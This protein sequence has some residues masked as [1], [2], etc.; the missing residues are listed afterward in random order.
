MTK[1]VAIITA[2]GRGKRMG[3][4][5]Q[6]LK[7]GGRPMLE[8]TLRVFDRC[9]AIDGIV[10]VVAK[11]DLSK[12]KRL[13]SK[14]LIGVVAGGPERHDSVWNGLQAVPADADLIAI[15]DGARPFVTAKVIEEAVSEAAKC[16]AVVVGVPIKDTVK[17][18]ESRTLNVGGT[19]D[20]NCLWAAQTPQVFKREIILRAYQSRGRVK[21]I[22]DDA[23]LVENLGIPVKMVLGSYANLKITTPE[24][25][26][27]AKG[28]MNVSFAK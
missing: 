21:N 27:L 17:K 2:G 25:L 26:V 5:K 18:V 14:K 28:A 13:Q 16:G 8:I 10:L 15:H 6:F 11:E 23:M 4:P 3:R 12:A 24:D 20:R 7:I 1:T 19:A 9:Q 22:T